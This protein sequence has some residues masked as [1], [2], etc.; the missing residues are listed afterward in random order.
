MI[1]SDSK[2]VDER[3]IDCLDYFYYNAIGMPGAIGM[4]RALHVWLDYG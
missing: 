2:R 1:L 3:G 4:I